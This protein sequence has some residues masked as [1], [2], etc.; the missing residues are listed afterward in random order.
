M[1]GEG[2]VGDKDEWISIKDKMPP[3]FT[4]VEMTDVFDRKR[5]IVRRT[6]FGSWKYKSGYVGAFISETDYWKYIK[7]KGED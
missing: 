5:S 2:Y 1:K 3:L 4:W 7:P 6:L